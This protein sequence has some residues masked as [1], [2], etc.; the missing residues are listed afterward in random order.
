M[1][2][3]QNTSDQRTANDAVPIRRPSN[4]G[5]HDGRR[6]RGV[7][8]EKPVKTKP[9]LD[10]DTLGWL[11][12]WFFVC[13]FWTKTGQKLMIPELQPFLLD[14]P[15]EIDLCVIRHGPDEKLRLL[16]PGIS[17][18]MAVNHQPVL[19]VVSNIHTYFSEN[20]LKNMLEFRVLNNIEPPKRSRFKIHNSYP[21]AN[22]EVLGQTTSNLVHLRH[23]IQL[24]FG[25][26]A[27]MSRIVPVATARVRH[28]P[29]LSPEFW[30]KSALKAVIFGWK[31]IEN[32]NHFS[33]IPLQFQEAMIQ[34]GFLELLRINGPNRTCSGFKYFVC[35]RST[36]PMEGP[37]WFLHVGFCLVCQLMIFNKLKHT[38]SS[39]SCDC[40][41]DCTVCAPCQLCLYNWTILQKADEGL[42][43]DWRICCSRFIKSKAKSSVSESV[44][45]FLNFELIGSAFERFC[46]YFPCLFETNALDLWRWLGC[47]T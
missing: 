7:P 33:E 27:A 35:K 2:V 8:S 22:F 4:V 32:E 26:V 10:H 37:H 21:S 28:G 13:F 29:L 46:W 20:P 19:G 9:F 25:K 15:D 6:R 34:D 17:V 23:W 38:V 30:A 44:L 45:C 3:L 42:T 18:Y 41:W 47:R 11:V 31:S 43:N 14:Q 39:F 36:S 1:L 24:D 16:I 40:S 12:C 5:V